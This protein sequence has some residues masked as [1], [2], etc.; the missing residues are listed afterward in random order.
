MNLKVCVACSGGGHLT[1]MLQI[2]DSY[3]EFEHFYVTFERPNS[4]DLAKREKVYFVECPSRNPLRLILNS[5]QSLK[6][7]LKEKPDV[8]I[9]TG[10]D[11]A[12]ATCF[13]AKLLGKKVIF[14]ESFCRINTASLSAKMVYP[15]A[16]LFLVQ[17]K[18]NLKFF[19]KG[20]YIGKVF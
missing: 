20:K 12:V 1:E 10:A 5:I 6:I 11:A 7:F 14:I 8:V 15:I 9:S 19:P 3:R 16:D 18:E 13:I 4:I 17:W 2:E